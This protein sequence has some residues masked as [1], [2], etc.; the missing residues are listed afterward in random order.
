MEDWSY[1]D[2]K[3][4]KKEEDSS[5]FSCIEKWEVEY[6]ADK[7]KKHY[8]SK[9]SNTIMKAIAHSCSQSAPPHP[10][11]KFVESVVS[12]LGLVQ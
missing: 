8:P 6:L 12:R 4:K 2:D 11:E 10:R 7:I 1:Y 9:D 5:K 3:K